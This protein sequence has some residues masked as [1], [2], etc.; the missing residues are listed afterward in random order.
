M[1]RLAEDVKS[2]FQYKYY[3]AGLALI[4]AGAYGF[5][6]THYAVGMDDTAVALYYEEG[7]APYVGRFS[8][9]LL[10]RVLGLSL[11]E[12]APWL[13]ELAS[14]LILMVSAT[15]WCVVWKRACGDRL[16]L[17]GWIYL[18][19]SGMFISC[20]LISEVFVFYLHNG[21]C[22]GYGITALAVLCLMGGLEREWPSVGRGSQTLLSGVLLCVALGFYESF[23][24]VYIMGAVMA[25]LL[26]RLF[27]GKRGG[28]V[29][30]HRSGAWALHGAA[31][32]AVGLLLRGAVLVILKWAYRLESLS[33]YDVRYRHLFGDIF[34]VQ[35][36]LA[37][38][39]KRFYVK[40]FVNAVVYFPVG[41]LVAAML[42]LT[43]YLL[44]QTVRKRDVLLL[45]CLAAVAALPVLM[46]LAEGLATRYRS[47]Q[48]VPLLCSFTVLL[49]L[50]QIQ[51]CRP[52][53]WLRVCC[54]VLLSI[55]LF[56][57]CA[58]MNKWFYVDYLKYQDAV[59]V[60]NQVACDLERE[61]D[62]SKPIV[63]R[64]AYK[65]PASL[66]QEAYVDFGSGE[67]RLI[68]ML[69]DPIDVHLKEKYYV[70]GTAAY[71][72]LEMPAVSVLQWGVTA[73]DDT[74]GQLIR[75]WE[76][77]GIEGFRCEMD[78]ERIDRAEQI[79]QE[80][81]MPGYPREGY[82]LECEDYIIVNLEN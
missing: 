64:G 52:R 76:M 27:V 46:S 30:D 20:P 67:Y 75:F 45:L 42:F 5:A 36:E 32:V 8:L 80:R 63:F 3:L 24:I 25:F 28:G 50:A 43:V 81:N 77:H 70:A 19:A 13:V 66:L 60:M 21:V 4:A 16:K 72:P 53:V 31:A 14:V 6:V 78:F 47:A 55:L 29:Y 34:T 68:C 9:F 11:G 57:Q 58:E 39:L 71:S 17:S 49:I 10:N 40:Y 82:I 79:R 33:V 74:A 44:Y 1:K 22:S 26:L 38:L 41:I 37:M 61:C 56:N 18:A 48:Y 54:G 51:L 15:L 12:F 73:F 65:V 35:G 69:T 23:L 7:L 59:R 2:F 62:I